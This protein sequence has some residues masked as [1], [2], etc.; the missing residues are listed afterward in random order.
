VEPVTHILTGVCLARTGP[1]RTTA[2][3][4]LTLA[5]AAELPDIDTLW[6]IRGP[7]ES[8]QH[9]RGIT[10]TFLGL[11]LEAA[12]LVAGIWAFHRRRK[13]RSFPT[14]SQALPP[15][16]GLLYLWA[17]VGLLSHLLLDYTNNYGLRPFFPFDPHWYAGSIVFIFDPWIFLLLAGALIA[18]SLFALVGAEV[19]AR[20]QPF[21]GRG[22]AIAALLTIVAYWSF[23]TSEHTK[24]IQ[25]AQQQSIT[26]PTPA[27]LLDTLV[28]DGTTPSPP[29]DQ[30]TV[31]LTAQR[32][33]A[34]PDPLSPFTWSTVTDF[35][36]VY[37]RAE[38][39]TRLNTLRA[40]DVL[41]PKP[42]WDTP[43]RTAAA[44]P[45]G[46]AYLDWSPMPFLSEMPTPTGGHLI[47]F[48]D[49]RFLGGRLADFSRAP[50][51]GT[52]TLDPRGHVVAQTMDGRSEH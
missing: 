23:R 4:T 15:R 17:I 41:T 38:A 39:D 12:F 51:T 2:Y 22:F 37:Q 44:S 33:L 1:N 36:P 24:A 45:L 43:E 20:R 27:V 3:A 14:P 9:H 31:F 42:A 32:S 25:L 7:V 28:P 34:S 16:W 13:P 52:V 47:T 50:L 35:G 8:F 49:P 48:Q 40:N 21:R 5:I 6:A 46:R 29:P 26:A 18:P 19:G 11:P 30:P 10:H